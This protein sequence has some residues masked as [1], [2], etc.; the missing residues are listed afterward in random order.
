MT[1]R[2]SLE[3][4]AEIRNA[5]ESYDFG[6]PEHIA[7]K[8]LAHIDA[9]EAELTKHCSK[10]ID[11]DTCWDSD[12]RATIEMLEEWLDPVNPPGYFGDVIERH[13]NDIELVGAVARKA[14]RYRETLQAIRAHHEDARM[15]PREQLYAIGVE[16][17]DGD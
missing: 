1:N 7:E 4:L 10:D 14:Q 15:T 8:L 2:L 3:E 5:V 11:C 12:V 9:L 13:K 17:K 6:T 16:L